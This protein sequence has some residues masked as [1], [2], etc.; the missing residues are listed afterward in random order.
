MVIRTRKA[1]FAP[2]LFEPE[3]PD[4]DHA[5]SDQESHIKSQILDHGHL[6]PKGQVWTMGTQ[7]FMYFSNQCDQ[8]IIIFY[9]RIMLRPL[10][11]IVYLIVANCCRLCQSFRHPL[12]EILQVLSDASFFVHI[13]LVGFSTFA[14]VAVSLVKLR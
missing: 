13:S 11:S 12:E 7:Y 6:E 9:I 14:L 5:H 1:K 10:R 8:K 3:K 2:W 4:L